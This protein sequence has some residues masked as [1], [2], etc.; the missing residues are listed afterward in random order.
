[1]IRLTDA[2][3]LTRSGRTTVSCGGYSISLPAAALAEVTS[4]SHQQSRLHDRTVQ[5]RRLWEH[6]LQLRR[7]IARATDVRLIRPRAASPTESARTILYPLFYPSELFIF[8]LCVVIWLTSIWF[9][10]RD[11]VN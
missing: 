3:W 9:H 6:A 5:E 11:G 8:M 4:D 2:G 1:M 7:F 10:T